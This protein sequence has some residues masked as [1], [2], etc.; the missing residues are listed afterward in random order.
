VGG[1]LRDAGEQIAMQ[2]IGTRYERR[3]GEP[4]LRV[5]SSLSP[6]IHEDR[7]PA[8]VASDDELLRRLSESLRLSRRTE[9]DLVAHVAEVDERRLYSAPRPAGTGSHP[10]R[11]LSRRFVRL[12]GPSAWRVDLVAR[13]RRDRHCRWSGCGSRGPVRNRASGPRLRLEWPRAARV[14]GA[15]LPRRPP[16]CHRGGGPPGGAP[17]QAFPTCAGV[18]DN[19]YG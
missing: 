1:L 18:G 17:R 5:A 9:A 11:A 16:A 14:I 8:A 12:R 4:R 19:G 6:W 10:G 13:W 7:T 3:D 15:Q 2:S